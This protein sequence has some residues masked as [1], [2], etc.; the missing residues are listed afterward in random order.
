MFLVR[1]EHEASVIYFLYSLV[2]SSLLGQNI[3]HRTPHHQPTFLPQS[4][5]QGLAA[6]QNNKN[7]IFVCFDLC[8]FGQQTGRQKF[9]TE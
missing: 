7:C 2:T 9:Y 8:I 1:T 4:G 6:M 5:T 3:F